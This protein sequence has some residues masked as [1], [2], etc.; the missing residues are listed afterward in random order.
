LT[1]G[2]LR[3]TLI[4]HGCRTLK[5]KRSRIRPILARVRDKFPVSAAEVDRQ[6]TVDAAVLAFVTV[7]A[8]EA[9]VDS[10]LNRIVDLVEG[11]GLATIV[12]SELEMMHW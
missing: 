9:T 5:E 12:D 1:I 11:L 2:A 4:L 3:L 7:S 10:A 8:D 6:N